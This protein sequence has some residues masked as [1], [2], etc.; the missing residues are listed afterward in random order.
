MHI[1]GARIA[2]TVAA[3]DISPRDAIGDADIVTVGGTKNGMLLGE[4]IL[5]RHP[6]SFDGIHFVQ[7]QIGHLASK[8]R[9]IAAQFEALMRDD[10]WLHNAATANAMAARLSTGM[11]ERGLHLASTTD[12]N[13]VFVNLTSAA[14]ARVSEHYV[15]H[16][17]DPLQPAVR[18]VC[19]WATTE[20]EVVD[21]LGLLA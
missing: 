13:E 3:L 21:V 2:N 7:K 19:S 4:A 1:D 8:Q 5:V 14:L 11:V 6:E 20:R 10:L 17:P 9:F 18:F 12:A 16:Q 15:V